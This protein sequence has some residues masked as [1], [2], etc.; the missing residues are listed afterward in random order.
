MHFDLILAVL[1]A[2]YCHA[3]RAVFSI[4]Y[5]LSL[6][7]FRPPVTRMAALPPR[8]RVVFSKSHLRR[9]MHCDVTR[10]SGVA[11]FEKVAQPRHIKNQE[12][13]ILAR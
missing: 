9:R 8:A 1:L 7:P 2:G 12:G 11:A 3:A 5:R 10:V 6:S 13:L 4:P